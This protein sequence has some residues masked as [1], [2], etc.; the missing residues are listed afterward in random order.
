MDKKGGSSKKSEHKGTKQQK[1][2]WCQPQVFELIP[3][4][5]RVTTDI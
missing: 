5:M 1:N 3:Y 2:L 4:V